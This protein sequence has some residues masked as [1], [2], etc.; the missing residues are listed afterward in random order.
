VDVIGDLEI[1]FVDSDELSR[2]SFIG[3]WVI[4]DEMA[5]AGTEVILLNFLYSGDAGT[6]GSSMSCSVV[7]EDE[8]DVVDEPWPISLCRK[9]GIILRSAVVALVSVFRIPNPMPCGV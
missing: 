3:V 2:N 4:G 1:L 5:L 6:V 9:R 8:M 7:T